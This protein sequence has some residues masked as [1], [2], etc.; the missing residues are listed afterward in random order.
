MTFLANCDALII[1]V[2][3]NGGGSRKMVGLLASFLFR[4]RTHLIDYRWREGDRVEPEWTSEDLAVGKTAEIP[5]YVVTSRRTFSAAEELSYDLK[6][7]GRATIVGETTRGGANPGAWIALSDSLR[8]F[9]PLGRAVSPI[10]GTNWEGTGVIPDVSAPAHQALDAAYAM[11]LDRLSSSA[12]D[13]IQIAQLSWAKVSVAARLHPWALSAAEAERYAGTYGQRRVT[14]SGT[15]LSIRYE[16]LPP[17]TMIPLA[18]GTFALE[19]EDSFRVRFEGDT[20]GR[21]AALVGLTEGGVAYRSD[22]SPD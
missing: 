7:L 2:R 13:P 17:T 18:N 22:R 20:N 5:V 4:S 10:S 1:D 3:D 14:R 16:D 21:A 19:G 12:T 6:T 9:M 11:A 15:S 8:V